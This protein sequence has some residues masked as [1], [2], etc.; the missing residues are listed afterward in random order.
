M[1][2]EATDGN[3]PCL[4]RPSNVVRVQ[5]QGA[6]RQQLTAALREMLHD[7]SWPRT[8]AA[9]PDSCNA[10]LGSSV[11]EP[12]SERGGIEM[13]AAQQQSQA[14]KEEAGHGDRSLEA[15]AAGEQGKHDCDR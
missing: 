15:R 2:E 3:K 10:E 8:T 11:E 7:D 13:S 9:S 4:A 14:G 1:L 5:L 12:L 6:R